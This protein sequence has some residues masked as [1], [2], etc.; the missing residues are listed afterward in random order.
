MYAL[1]RDSVSL[2]HIG[3]FHLSQ[4]CRGTRED[5]NRFLLQIVSLQLL[6]VC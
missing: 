6:E 3:S 5:S 4:P 2:D 1:L